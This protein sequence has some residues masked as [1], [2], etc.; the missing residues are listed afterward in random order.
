M[1]P[2]HRFPY[3]AL[4]GDGIVNMAGDSDTS[5]SWLI[6]ADRWLHRRVYTTYLDLM[7]RLRNP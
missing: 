7:V 1:L 2:T 6:I 4:S 5:A 3:G